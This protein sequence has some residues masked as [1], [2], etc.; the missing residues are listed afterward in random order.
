[1]LLSFSGIVGFPGQSN[2]C[3]GNTYQD[4]LAEYR[5]SIG[6]KAAAI[7]LEMVLSVCFS[8]ERPEIARSLRD[9]TVGR[10]MH[11]YGMD[12][13]VAVDMRNWLLKE[14]KAEVSAADLLKD[15]SITAL[16]LTI[17]AKSQF[18]PA[19]VLQSIP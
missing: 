14:V 4:A 5:V 9:I 8:A 18:L 16:G 19:A 13:L 6:E 17:A 3:A 12:S 15:V 7:D 11:T 10:P 1:M 2:Y